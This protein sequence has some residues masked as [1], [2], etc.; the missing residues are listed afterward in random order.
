PRRRRPARPVVLV[1]CRGPPAR[2]VVLLDVIPAADAVVLVILVV[3]TTAAPAPRA[4]DPAGL[5]VLGVI[6]QVAAPAAPLGRRD[7]VG[8]YEEADH[9]GDDAQRA[10]N[11]AAGHVAG[12]GDAE[13]DAHQFGDDPADD[14]PDADQ[15]RVAPA[16]LVRLA[17]LLLQEVNQDDF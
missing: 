10:Q 6:V 1:P 9:D 4:A 12:D 8:Q 15:R 14:E 16:L 5:L 17:D 7:H 2:A 3:A 13:E 11:Q